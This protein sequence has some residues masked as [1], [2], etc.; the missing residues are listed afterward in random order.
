M[1]LDLKDNDGGG[2]GD[3]NSNN[4]NNNNNINSNN[5]N[6]DNK[7]SCCAVLTGSGLSVVIQG[8]F[9]SAILL[10]L[11]S[12]CQDKRHEAPYWTW[13]NFLPCIWLEFSSI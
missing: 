4:S 3:I 2:G 12:K 1:Y 9:E 8:S 6:H 13:F 11:D 7:R 5:N 10:P